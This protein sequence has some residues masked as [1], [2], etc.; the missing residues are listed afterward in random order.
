MRCRNA[1]ARNA[2]MAVP[3]WGLWLRLLWMTRLQSGSGSPGSPNP[4]TRQRRLSHPS[5]S[6]TKAC[7]GPSMRSFF[8]AGLQGKLEGNLI[9]GPDPNVCWAKPW[10]P[11]LE[12]L[13]LEPSV[14]QLSG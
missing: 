4:I 13:P 6:G 3:S 8:A 14:S 9:P 11:A 7:K 12:D 5:P 1:P 2:L 10:L